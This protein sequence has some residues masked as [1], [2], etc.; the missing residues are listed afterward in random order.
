MASNEPLYVSSPTTV[1]AG[2]YARTCQATH[3]MGRLIRIKDDRATDSPLRFTEAAQLYRT[4]EALAKILLDELQISAAQYS[5]PLALCYGAILHICDPFCCTETNRGE[6]TVE[7]TEM[8]AI[9]IAGLK[10]T[11]P[12][13]VRFADSLKGL[14]NHNISAV[15]PLT[16]DAIYMGASTYAWLA[17][18]QG[19]PEDLANYHALREVLLQMNARWAAAGEFLKVLDATKDILYGDNPN[20]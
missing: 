4:L 10:K 3:L 12:D 13:V 1:R 11:G 15:S 7:E 8:Q 9:A 18:E 19:S 16:A 6:H 20:L 14:M 2:A 17:H 5:T